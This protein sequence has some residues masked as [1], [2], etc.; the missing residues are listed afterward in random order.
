MIA[1]SALPNRQKDTAGETSRKAQ[2]SQL[3]NY[4]KIP[5][6]I[7]DCPFCGAKKNINVEIIRSTFNY[8]T[9][10]Y[11]VVCHICDAT[12]SV[13]ATAREAVRAWNGV[14]ARNRR[15]SL[16][17]EAH[18]VEKPPDCDCLSFRAKK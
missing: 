3:M 4:N 9:L 14:L 10:I 1:S 13:E 5:L 7:N 15:N 18:S 8:K 12:G 2:L 6:G 11:K 16:K 17:Q